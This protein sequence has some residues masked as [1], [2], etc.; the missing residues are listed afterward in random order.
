MRCF[1]DHLLFI[2]YT[3]SRGLSRN[4]W[5]ILSSVEVFNLYIGCLE[6]TALK[7]ISDR[8]VDLGNP[9]AKEKARKPPFRDGGRID[10]KRGDIFLVLQTGHRGIQNSYWNHKT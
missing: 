4:P 6:N 7:L 3:N 9:K 10:D 5:M 8:A 1:V 2:D